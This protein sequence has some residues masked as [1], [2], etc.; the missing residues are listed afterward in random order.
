MAQDL[1]INGVEAALTT[2]DDLVLAK[3]G[4]HLTTLQ[5][6][7]FRGSWS[8]QKYE[9]IAQ[10]YYCSDTHVRIVGAELWDLLSQALGEKVTKKTFRAALERHRDTQSLGHRVPD[11]P[12]SMELVAQENPI[13]LELSRISDQPA[14]QPA[15]RFNSSSNST[16][17][18]NSNSN[19]LTASSKQDWGEA[20]DVAVFYGRTQ[21]QELL[22][23]WILREHCRLI[24]LLG[25]GGIGKTALTAKLSQD[26][27][28][29][30]EFV[31]WR[32]LRNAPTV[33]EILGDLI[34]FLSNHQENCL[35]DSLDGKIRKL[36][37]QV[38]HQRCLI[39]LDN[40]ESILQ[41]G[42]RTGRYRSGLEGY[43]QLFKC[44]GEARHQSCLI[45]TSR[46]KPAQLSALEGEARPVRCL[47]LVGLLPQ[48]GRAIF[49]TKGLFTGTETDW[50]ALNHRYAGN[51]LALNIVSSAIQDFLIGESGRISPGFSAGCVYFR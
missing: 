12:N 16:L 26:L 38:R 51:P 49:Q 7:I 28:H 46:E 50:Q 32:S 10:D 1:A 17:N 42:D 19:I 18:S 6:A 30:F 4:K 2:A 39:I 20:P 43:G 44:L 47:N 41:G 15:S 34:Q 48:D 29:Q 14:I 21:E 37:D 25:M 35:P 23:H 33:D 22:E 31:I 9:Q 5:A 36:I 3:T 24:T 13:N 11:E 45:L 8:G 27:A 40:V